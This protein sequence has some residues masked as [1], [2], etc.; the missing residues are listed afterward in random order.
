MEGRSTTAQVQP[1]RVWLPHADG[2]DRMGGAPDGVAV[3]VFDG[4]GEPPDS[5]DEVEFYVPPAFASGPAVDVLRRMPRLTVVQSL[6]AGV[7][8][9]VAHI[10]NGVTLCDARGVHDTSTA[11][12]VVAATLA[13]VRRFPELLR[14]QTAGR[15]DHGGTESLAGKTVLIV[16]AGAIGAAV[17][18]RLA[19][20]EV[21]ILQVARRGRAGVSPAEDLPDLLGRADVVVVLVP[22]TPLTRGLVDA[23]FLARLRDGALLVNAARGPVVDT[24]ALVS[25]LGSGRIRAALDVTE[26]E[27]LPEGHPLWA[28]PGLL[29]TP[30]VAGS[31][32]LFLPK[33]YR[34]VRRQ[35]DRYLAGATLDNVVTDGY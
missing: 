24:D 19:G 26:P 1:T 32:P 16:G 28:V 4:V 8:T 18:E 2:V 10:P 3:D 9:V 30:H 31:T 12:W 20:F 15:W 35:L 17:A 6:N 7:D 33:A 21:E 22:L 13:S 25:E 23:A 5:I 27:P 34:L 11:E 14:A 29:L